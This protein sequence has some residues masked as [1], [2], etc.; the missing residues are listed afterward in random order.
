MEAIV[1]VDLVFGMGK[2][3]KLPWKIKQDLEFFRKTTMGHILVMGGKTFRSLGKPL[4]GR[5][6]LV[7]SKRSIRESS[8]FDGPFSNVLFYDNLQDLIIEIKHRL[9]GDA[10]RVFL[11]GGAELFNCRHLINLVDTIHLT[12]IDARYDCDTFF[13]LDFS[14]WIMTESQPSGVYSHDAN[15]FIHFFKF[16]RENNCLEDK[17]QQI[18]SKE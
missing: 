1:A 9:G 10:R 13:E 3:G 17:N 8:P 6:H 14:D 16:L 5:L 4:P 2:D 18:T 7:L 12:R 11:I 15:A